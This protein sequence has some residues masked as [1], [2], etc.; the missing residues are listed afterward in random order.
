[1]LKSK[2]AFDKKAFESKK[3]L[4][5]NEL[6]PLENTEPIADDEAE[7]AEAATV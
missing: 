7:I 3:Q 1:M 4:E 5:T 2:E 6:L